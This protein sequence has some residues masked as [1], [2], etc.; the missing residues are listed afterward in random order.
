M[1]AQQFR[2]SIA[3]LITDPQGAAVP[4]AKVAVVQIDT[5]AKAETTS[6]VSG[7]FTLPFLAPG[8]YVLTIEALG[9]KNYNYRDLPVN[10]NEQT[11]ADVKL[12]IGAA[13]E[14]VTITGGTPL[15]E[16]ETASTG[17]VINS[18]QVENM[19]LN[20]R[21]PLVL[22]Q[23]AFGVIP[24]SD[25]RFYRPFDD[26]GPS[27]FAM[28]GGASKQNELLLDGT[29]DFSVGGGLGFSPPVDSV[30]EVKVESFQAD[31]AYGHTGGG[32]ANVTT[33]S[34]TN[35]FH[36]TAYDFNQTSALG[37]TLFFTNLAGQKKPS[38]NYN[39]WGITSGGPVIIPRVFD[40]K[41]KLFFFFAYEGIQEKVPQA[42]FTTVPTAVER[43][44][45]FSALLKLGGNY[46]IYDPAT[47]V[48]QGSRVARSPFDGNII[49]SSRISPI[50]QNILSYMDLPNFS[51]RADGTNNYYIGTPGELDTFDSELGRID[52]NIS[53]RHK[54]F[55]NFRHNDRLLEGGRTFASN[56]AT[57]TILDQVNWG[58]TL[59]DVYTFAPS[60]VLNTRFNFL[61]N[62]ELRKGYSDGFDYTTLG[63][64]KSLLAYST[65]TNFPQI[66]ID[67]FAGLGSSRGGGLYNPYD[68]FQIFTSLN[69]TFGRQTVKAGADLR[70]LRHNNLTNGQSS[71]IYNF[72][73]TFTRGPLDNSPAGPLGQDMASL[74][75]GLPTGGSWDDNGGES[76]QNGYMA[77]FIQDDLRLRPNLTINMG[78]RLE[79]EFATTERYNRSVNGFDFNSPSPISDAARAAYAASPVAGPASQFVV[80]GGLLFANPSNRSLFQ[81]PT[82][83]IGPRF[84]ISWAPKALGGKTVVRAGMGLFFFP[85]AGVGTG[86][87]QT[88][89][90][91][92]T[93]LVSSLDGN[94]TPY[95]TLAN[96]YPDGIQLPVGSSQALSTYLGKSVGYMSYKLKSG[97]SYR[98]T[99]DVQRQLGHDIVVEVGYE[100]NHGV[101]LGLNRSLAVVPA[102]YLSTSPA[103]D[104]P[105]IDYL[106]ANVAN[107]FAGLIPGTTLNGSTVQRQQLLQ[108]FPQFTGLTERST[109]QGAS[110]FE[111]VQARVEKR[112]SHGF[113]L[114]ANFLD[115]KLLER[116]SFLNPQDG[117]PEKRISADDRPWRFVLS[118]NWDLPFGKGRGIGSMAGPVLN[119]IIGGWT[120]NAIY[121]IQPGPPLGWGNVIYLGGPLNPDPRNIYQAFDV[122][123]FNR[124]SSQQLAS[125]LRT[126]PS[127][128][129]SLRADGVN[130]LDL[131]IIK[132]L[133]IKEEMRLQLRG[134][135]FNA[136]NHPEFNP[137]NLTPTNSAFGTITSQANLA[138]STQVALRLVW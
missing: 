130:N 116:R 2:G 58:S 125:N 46:Q 124:I 111:L 75:L 92:S 118:A 84:G 28:G 49:P 68:V 57:G 42:S 60:L 50:A 123:R 76:S 132:N 53:D 12:E 131:S 127:Q 10:T 101:H 30:T 120:V 104:Q 107:P 86:V 117:M 81:T 16:T 39:Q 11:E 134:E 36:G 55:Y 74:L 9:F 19:P 119:R 62:S 18:K 5:G 106:T 22:A 32:T 103:H 52:Y 133:H 122:T 13:T 14:S 115:S 47:G 41:N 27:S 97:Y 43:S 1:L 15:V 85:N 105:A 63:F 100:G 110:Y 65:H 114:L 25:P 112:F 73:T 113:Q 83:N 128:F 129:T 89:F 44:G 31:A 34:G 77:Y 40:G 24:N 61:Q 91:N 21:T 48:K 64:P 72:S 54:I 66:N 126:F 20:G 99:F 108:S 3:G 56:D 137:A 78:L 17:Q 109:P 96:P 67:N 4:N 136:C 69:K 33:K 45:D 93:S 37:A 7:R 82:I 80:N 87:D 29:P 121:T 79:H 59:D 71:G 51:G 38:T 88:G 98:W 95:A 90:N 23:L 94:L 26:S 102:Q 8:K 35:S 135:F 138:R 6:G 70:L